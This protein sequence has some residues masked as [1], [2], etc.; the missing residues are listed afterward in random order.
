MAR[1]RL[2]LM[3]INRSADLPLLARGDRPF[4]ADITEALDPQQVVTRYERAWRLSRPQQLGD[5]PV[6]H[7]K[8]GFQSAQSSTDEVEYDE[9][10]E[11]FIAVPNSRGRGQFSYYVLDLE[12]R[13]MIFEERRDIKRTSFAGALRVILERTPNPQAVFEAEFVADMG[14]FDDWL[15]NTDRVTRFFVSIRQPNPNWD[16]RD[17]M[18]RDIMEQ[19]NAARMNLEAK[20]PPDGPG[21]Q[22]PGSGLDA[23][24]DHAKQTYGVVRASG[25]VQQNRKFFDSRRKFASTDIDTNDSEP[26][27]TYLRRLLDMLKSIAPT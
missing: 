22:I 8:L 2:W 27:G 10:A 14:E 7:G 5:E 11:D 16:D 19:S 6:L 21:L 15:A 13:Y 12:D 25:E 18:I 3:R 17:N 1:R 23:F 26:E 20:P 24:I 9:E 4:Q